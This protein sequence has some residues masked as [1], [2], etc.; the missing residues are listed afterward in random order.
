MHV[1]IPH[2]C[3]IAVG[4]RGRGPTHADGVDGA[5]RSGAQNGAD[6]YRATDRHRTLFMFVPR[7]TWHAAL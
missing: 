2:A 4:A 1:R 3:S 6:R 5:A 7:V